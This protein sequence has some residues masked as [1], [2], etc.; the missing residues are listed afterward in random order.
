MIDDTIRESLDIIKKADALNPY[1]KVGLFSGG[2]DSLLMLELLKQLGVTLD[3]VIHVD[4]G[5]GLPET[6]KYVRDYCSD[7]NNSHYVEASSGHA[8]EDFVLRKGFFGTGNDAHAFAYH[9]LKVTALDK[10]LATTITKRIKNRKILLFNGIRI[11]ESENRKKNYGD[12]IINVYPR[13]PN[14]FWV[15]VIHWWTEREKKEY[16]H[17][18]KLNPVSVAIGRSGECMCGTMQSN[19]D[20]MAASEFSPAWGKWLDQ[21]ERKV[22]ASGFPW[23]WGQRINKYHLME[24]KGQLNMFMPTC[25]GCKSNPPGKNKI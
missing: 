25:V 17:G 23:R 19:A 15:N 14:Q 24:K 11:E 9:V 1:A 4:T 18:F 16:L 20:R 21:L 13:R 2:S 6:I 5:T 7:Y 3:F 12:E 8:Y 10:S 22:I